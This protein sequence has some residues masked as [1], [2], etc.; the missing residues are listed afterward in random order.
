MKVVAIIPALSGGSRLPDKNLILVNG[1]PMISYVLRAASESNVF[2]EIYV[3]S[4]IDLLKNISNK[5]GAKFYERKPERG[6]AECAMKNKSADCGG[7][8]CQVHD[9]Y[10]LD[11]LENTECDIV[12]QIHTTS[13][14]IKPETIKNFVSFMVEND[15]ASCFCVN[16]HSK[17]TLYGTEPIN[18][19]KKIKTPTQELEPI[20]E[21]SWAISAWNK[22]R[23]IGSCMLDSKDRNGPTY[24]DKMGLFPISKIEA[25]DV[26][27]EEDLF[28][29]E[30]CLNHEKRKDNV[31]RFNYSSNIID[32]EKDLM[33]LISEDGSPIKIDN[34]NQRKTNIKKLK[35]EIGD[36]SIAY[37]VI[38]TDNDQCCFIQQKP[39]EGCRYHYHPTKDEFWIILQGKF[40][41]DIEDEEP[42]VGEQ[43][44]IIF[45]EKGKPHKMTCIGNEI[46]IRLACGERDMSHI[47]L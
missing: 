16:Q 40:K 28:I 15:Y 19:S 13:P 4:D 18:F 32:I 9:H 26:D 41:F 1:E 33:K 30:A 2:D 35:E 22:E 45:I 46:G 21:I 11:F 17:E 6:G 36:E 7:G 34:R 39:G 8:R 47:Y 42:T 37:P 38:W 12:V 31:G 25:I 10:I 24:M 3:N 43:G 23:F 44:D 29:A 20:N 27:T 14:L 5:Y